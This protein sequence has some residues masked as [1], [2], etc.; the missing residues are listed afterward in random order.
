VTTK[1]KGCVATAKGPLVQQ[2]PDP[3]AAE[4]PPTGG[5][6]MQVMVGKP[7]P[8]FEATAYWN[9]GFSNMK[10]SDFHGKWV[11]LCFYPG[12]FTFV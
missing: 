9:G 11:T 1:H 12:D 5:C 3:A 4:G 2:G 6:A 10:L 7:A 8:D